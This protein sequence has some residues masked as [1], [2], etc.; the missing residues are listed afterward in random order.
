MF[1]P[2]QENERQDIQ[3]STEKNYFCQMFTDDARLKNVPPPLDLTRILKSYHKRNDKRKIGAADT[4]WDKSCSLIGQKQ[5]N[6]FQ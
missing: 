5:Q 3:L 4:M 6:T 2:D 1:C